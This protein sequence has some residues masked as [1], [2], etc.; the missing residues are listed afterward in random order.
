MGKLT[1]IIQYSGKLSNSVGM[2]G[3][4]GRNY[5]RIRRTEIKNPKSD[6][7]CIQRMILATVAKSIAFLSVV[8]SSAVEGK[9]N[10]AETLAY[11]RGQWMRMLRTN[12]IISA[13]SQ[14]EYLKKNAD[15]FSL[16]PYLLSKGSIVAPAFTVDGANKRIVSP[17]LN[18][19]DVAVSTASDI[20]LG[21]A[22]GNQITIVAVYNDVASVTDGVTPRRVKYCRFAFKDNTTV[23]LDSEGH[24]NS[25]AL[26]L[27]KAQGDWISLQFEAEHLKLGDFIGNDNELVGASI[28][29]SNI[30]GKQRSTSYLVLADNVAKQWSGAEAYQTYGDQ[31][32]PIDMVSSEYLNNSAVIGAEQSGVVQAY[33]PLFLADSAA[34]VNFHLANAPSV[35]T[36]LRVYG[37]ENSSPDTPTLSNNL[38]VTDV[39]DAIGV[40]DLTLSQAVSYN[41]TRKEI[42]C[43]LSNPGDSGYIITGG[44]AICDGVK[45]TF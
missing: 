10:G 27:V 34:G 9:A 19:I 43:Q 23:A 7:Q 44:Y 22:V 24:L 31:A 14:Y 6:A 2:R 16:N 32:V 20:F 41:I 42:D 40:G 45:Y 39:D 21:V 28:L 37:K 5:I 35:P 33:L 11:L 18:D 1:G 17:A 4:D 3:Q 8:L 29:I 15:T 25:G 13:D 26:D 30:E 12:D 36:D 38:M